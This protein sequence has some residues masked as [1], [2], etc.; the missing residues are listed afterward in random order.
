MLDLTVSELQ[1]QDFSLVVGSGERIQI[2]TG[3]N[4]GDSITYAIDT[5]RNKATQINNPDAVTI[6]ILGIASKLIDIIQSG[7][8]S[9][10]GAKAAAIKV[11]TDAIDKL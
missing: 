4:N 6:S 2:W 8:P 5:S 1:A 7:I 11:I 10:A 9:G 3:N